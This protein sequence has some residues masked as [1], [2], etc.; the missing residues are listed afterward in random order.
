M[1]LPDEFWVTDDYASRIAR[2]CF[3]GSVVRT[4]PNLYLEE[5]LRR[6]T[7]LR[8]DAAELLYVLEPARDDW[9]RGVPGEFQA[10]DYFLQRMAL[11][12]LPAA[13]LIR[14]R[15][16]PS[17]PR[18]KYDA[19]ITRQRNRNIVL[20]D[21]ADVAAALSRA[22]WVAGCETFALVIGLLAGRRAIC[23][24]PPWAPACRLP[25]RELVH[26]KALEAGVA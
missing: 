22:A 3:P 16:H 26:L 18:G 13:T 8:S 21:S 19:W 2:A 9:G 24:L 10:L 14:L 15:P 11:L 25:H 6:I 5:Q 12:E 4:Q 17:D 23:T 20:D 1:V 7:P